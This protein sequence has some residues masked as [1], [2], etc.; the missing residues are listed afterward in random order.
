MNGSGWPAAPVDVV[1]KATVV[2]SEL[3]CHSIVLPTQY[4]AAVLLM[5]SVAVWFTEPYFT[6]FVCFHLNNS[7]VL[8][9]HSTGSAHAS[10]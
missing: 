6:A 1:S 5:C 8:F 7:S 2:N 10:V 3:Y 9:L 4:I